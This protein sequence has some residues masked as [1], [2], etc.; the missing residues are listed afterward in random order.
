MF[1]WGEGRNPLEEMLFLFP[2][3][4]LSEAAVLEAL[5]I[6][7]FSIYHN[8]AVSSQGDLGWVFSKDIHQILMIVE[9]T[10]IDSSCWL[11]H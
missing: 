2:N 1:A 3:G 11:L 9:L 10:Q 6:D 5:E 7:I 8:S 4:L